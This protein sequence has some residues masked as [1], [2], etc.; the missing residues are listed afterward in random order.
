[1][2]WC[3]AVVVVWCRAVVVVWCRAVVAVWCRA[4]VVAERLLL[5]P[6]DDPR[7]KRRRQFCRTLVF[8]RLLKRSKL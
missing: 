7:F 8:S 5:T 1:M 3:R 4:V 6:A 2:V